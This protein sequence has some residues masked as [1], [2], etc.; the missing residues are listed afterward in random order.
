[1]KFRP[2][3]LAC[4]ALLLPA[5][6][7]F[8]RKPKEEPAPP[9]RPVPAPKLP[10]RVDAAPFPALMVKARKPVGSFM[11]ELKALSDWAA[12]K[13]IAGTPFFYIYDGP[14]DG[15]AQRWI[16]DAG[17]L[18]DAA[19]APGFDPGPYELRTVPPPAQRMVR[20]ITAA[21]S[22]SGEVAAAGSAPGAPAAGTPYTDTADPRSGV[23]HACQEIRRAETEFYHDYFRKSLADQPD[24]LKGALENYRYL[25]PAMI[26]MILHGMKRFTLD[27]PVAM[28]LRVPHYEADAKGPTMPTPF[29]EKPPQPAASAASAPA[30][31][32][33]KKKSKAKPAA[34][35]SAPKAKP[36]P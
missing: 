1:M 17:L 27:E 15:T 22:I 36:A 4:F 13:K 25:P 12:E 18:L 14:C 20:T 21:T 33:G 3:S 34:V 31:S 6:A 16:S 26:F 35:A 2:V 9:A 30:S 8:G 7:A 32:P 24:R 23:R 10:E 11:A 28:E 19:P 29:P 5:I